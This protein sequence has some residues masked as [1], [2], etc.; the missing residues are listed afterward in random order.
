[1][2]IVVLRYA[3]AEQLREFLRLLPG[4]GGAL[5]IAAQG[6]QDFAEAERARIAPAR[7]ALQLLQLLH[8][9]RDDAERGYRVGWQYVYCALDV[10]QRRQRLGDDLRCQ[11][12]RFGSRASVPEIVDIRVGGQRRVG[13][14]QPQHLPDQRLGSRPVRSGQR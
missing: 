2:R 4:G 10:I 13:V 7:R 9:R 1:M 6:Q 5:R 8:D 11:R 12:Q 3:S 14:G